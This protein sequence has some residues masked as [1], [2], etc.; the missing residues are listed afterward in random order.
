ML[1]AINL[2]FSVII[3]MAENLSGLGYGSLNKSP[4]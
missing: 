2:S 4:T 1:L 3:A